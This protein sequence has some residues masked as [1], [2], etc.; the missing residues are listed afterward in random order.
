MK[1]LLL[2]GGMG[3]VGKNII[4][5]LGSKYSIINVD[6]SVDNHFIQLHSAKMEAV[7]Q[8]DLIKEEKIYEICT[9]FQPEIVINL[10]SVVTAERD[11]RLFPDMIEKNLNILLRLYD[12]LKSIRSLEVF[13]QFGSCEEYGA[14]ASP[15]KESHRER[16]NSPYALAKQLTTNT[17][18]MLYE[19]YK[20]PS[21]VV[22]PSNIFGPYQDHSKFIPYVISKLIKNEDLN[23]TKCEQKRDFIYVKDLIRY[24]EA[25][26]ISKELY[27]GKIINIGSGYSF[28][29]KEIVEYL[30]QMIKSE[31][32]IFYG[33][34]P[35][36]AN[37]IMDLLPDLDLLH[38][39]IQWRPPSLFENLK[40]FI[41]QLKN[42]EKRR[43]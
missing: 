38:S 28:P 30:K 13:I 20:F 12:A 5:S 19:N 40:G 27:I 10:V 39:K 29:L 17:A 25:I 42:D 8:T 14:I 11:L 36:R 24:L 26:I 31:S 33:A 16:P 34:L 3:F 22:R 7:F 6:R 32:R 15:L 23:L 35:Y 43:E 2:V 1:R 37:E 41:E 18:M 4:E 21:L 9:Q